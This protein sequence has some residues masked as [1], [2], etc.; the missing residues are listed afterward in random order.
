MLR[1]VQSFASK[2]S[3]T[4]TLVTLFDATIGAICMYAVIHWRYLAEGKPV[5]ANIDETAAVVFF[6]SCVITWVLTDTHK[7]IWRFT[8]L[9]DIKNLL[10]AVV[11]ASFIAPAILFFFFNRAEDFPRSVPFIVG[12]LFFFAIT[13]ARTIALFMQNGDIRAMFRRENDDAPIA[14]LVGTENS[15]HNYM[16][17]VSRK[18]GGFNYSIRGLVGTDANHRGRS[19]RGIPV[20]GNLDDIRHVIEELKTQFGQAPT[21]IA[22]D[23][24]SNRESSYNL[25]RL[26]SEAGAPLVRVS[27]S[28]SDKLTPFEAT[29]LIGREVK[30]LDVAQVRRFVSGRKVLVTGAGGTI[31]SE[32]TRQIAI[33]EPQR[34]ALIDNSEFNLYEIDRELNK[35]LPESKKQFWFP[36]LADICDPVQMSEIFELEKPE[37]IIHAAAMKH[38]PMGEINPLAAIKINIGGTCQLFELSLKHN[39]KSFTLISTDK[40]VNP[41]NMMGA[42]K[43][44]AEM[45]TMAHENNSANM[46]ACAVRFGNVLASTGSVIPLFEEQIASGGPVTVTHKDATRYFM[47]TEEAASLVL[48]A[49]ALNDTERTDLASIYV[50]EMGEPVKIAQLAR[51]LIR[52][53][54]YVPDR[55]IEIK[56]TGL[57]PGEKIHEK[58]TGQEENLEPTYVDGVQRFI[59]RMSNPEKIDAHIQDLLNALKQR[60]LDRIISILN[61]LVPQYKPNGTLTKFEESSTGAEIIPLSETSKR[62]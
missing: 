58:L 28:Q 18:A 50:L 53:R 2:P 21:I 48:Q 59:G 39:A 10:Q 56:Y 46:S 37:I 6:L 13:I 26:A 42:S 61:L 24:N 12:P 4:K 15:L 31:G 3:V 47:T 33:L 25:I 57:R 41:T 44:I 35:S 19:I 22:T 62:K 30:N 40:A 27:Q 45:L 36:Y 9:D 23:I 32:I 29:D 20:I 8:S 51:Q 5:P 17:D 11:L 54:G 55:D 1:S 7:A 14:I 16:R 52:L 34:L 49:A 38:V 60:D 43:R